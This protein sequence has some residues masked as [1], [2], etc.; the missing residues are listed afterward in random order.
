MSQ[1]SEELEELLC[2]VNKY[3]TDKY[4]NLGLFIINRKLTSNLLLAIICGAVYTKKAGIIRPYYSYLEICRKDLLIFCEW[5]RGKTKPPTVYFVFGNCHLFVQGLIV[6]SF[7]STMEALLLQSSL[8]YFVWHT[9]SR[10][11]WKFAD[12]KKG[13]TALCR[14]R[15]LSHT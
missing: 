15:R 4:L 6:S 3:V 5:E 14:S 1:T 8:K 7:T 10:N 9:W 13:L 2:C 11:W 12:A